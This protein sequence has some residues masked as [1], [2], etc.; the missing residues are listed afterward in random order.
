[1][2]TPIRTCSGSAAILYGLVLT[3]LCLSFGWAQEERLL[4]AAIDRKS[5]GATISVEQEPWLNIQPQGMAVQGWGHLR[6]IQRTVT[7]KMEH[8]LFGTYTQYRFVWQQPKEEE[9]NME[10]SYLVFEER[11]MI[12][13][14][15]HFTKGWKNPGNTNNE[16]VAGFP[17]ISTSLAKKDLGYLV[18]GGCFLWSALHGDWKDLKEKDFA[19]LFDGHVHGQPWV[20][21]SSNKTLV[22]SSINSFFVS[23]F[24]YANATTARTGVGGA[25]VIQAGLRTSLDGIPQNH[26]YSSVLVAGG[27]GINATLMKWGDALLAL[28]N[29]T[30][31]HVYDDFIL[32]HAGYFTDNGAYHY[33]GAHQP[34]YAN[35]EEA[36]LGVK[37][38]FRQQGI[39]IRYIQWDDWW[40][41]SKGDLPGMLSWTPKKDVF[42]S[43]FTNWLDMPLSMY[44]PGYSGENIWID[45]YKW[46]TVKTGHGDMSIPLDPKFYLDLFQNGTK[47]GMKLFEQ[48]F[49][50]SQ[51]IGRTNLT[52]TDVDS[53]RMWLSQ[54]N[55]AALAYNVT[56]QLC[57]PDSYH[58][59]QSTTLQSVTNARATYDNTRNAPSILAMGPNSL[60]FH[61][62]GLFASR[63]NIW[64][65]GPTVNQ[66]GCGNSDF[67]YEP[68]A[69][70]DNAVTVL[71]N[72]PYG[73]GD[74]VDHVN[75]TIVMYACRKDGWMLRPRWPLASMDFTYTDADAKTAKVWAAHDDFGQSYRW[76]YIIGVKLLHA[77]AI[78]PK[79]LIQGAFESFPS[80]MVA[81]KVVPDGAPPTEVHLFSE[82]APFFLPKSEPLNLPYDVTTPPHT[83]YAVAP[84]L[85]NNMV[86][87]GEVGKWASMSFGRFSLFHVK[88]TVEA[89]VIGS[90]G[91]TF[92]IAYM[93]NVKDSVRTKVYQFPDSCSYV[94]QHRNRVC[95]AILQCAPDYGCIFVHAEADTDSFQKAH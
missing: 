21:H 60:L 92:T 85:S 51:G 31:N 72:G 74:S 91:E 76:S 20:L 70:L 10:T 26:H 6:L 3:L 65:S 23:G 84:V 49:L 28:G 37:N 18:W 89:M 69:H 73:I 87:L 33:R 43:G 44:A 59:L 46:K 11:D 39:P 80:Q 50:C 12:I 24:A 63:D 95:E 13:F 88:G 81:W 75:K 82:D 94:D 36:L 34:E 9:Q 41:E 47:I 45:Q 68:N 2:L 71:S 66:T 1:M 79:R 57:M 48:D 19:G 8:P 27:K 58:L 40:M 53:G 86:I 30:R 62:L 56:L 64:T 16:I 42:P 29:K 32:A 17:A 93:L 78:T 52:R 4:Q 54:M 77:V 14:D 35:M 25:G 7:P 67:C 15:Q 90:P 5:G 83:H 55:D 22:W 38:G 61:A